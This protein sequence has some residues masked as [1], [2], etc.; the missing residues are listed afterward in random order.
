MPW[1]SVAEPSETAMTLSCQPPS[2][3]WRGPSLQILGPNSCL[4]R[5]IV[6]NCLWGRRESYVIPCR[7]KKGIKGEGGPD[8]VSKTADWEGVFERRAR[9]IFANRVGAMSRRGFQLPPW[10]QGSLVS[11]ILLQ[12]SSGPIECSIRGHSVN[13]KSRTCPPSMLSESLF[14]R[15]YCLLHEMIWHIESRNHPFDQWHRTAISPFNIEPRVAL[16]CSDGNWVRFRI[17]VDTI[18]PQVLEPL[19]PFNFIDRK[20]S[21]TIS[22]LTQEYAKV[23]DGVLSS[24]LMW[25]LSS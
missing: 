5:L 19:G 22:W 6:D 7:S 15:A 10:S 25:L 17:P 1:S 21:P 14:T 20:L 24:E 13:L 18:T 12:V 2:G 3:G 4:I 8:G 9:S 16:S 23:A 11:S